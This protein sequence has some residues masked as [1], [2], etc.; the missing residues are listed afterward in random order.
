MKAVDTD[1][2]VRLLAKDDP[3]QTAVAQRLVKDEGPVWVS[4]LVLVET[5]WVLESVFDL[6]KERVVR[7][8]AALLDNVDLHLQDEL[9]VARAL[10]RFKAGGR[11]DFTDCL[12]LES[13]RSAGHLPLGTFDR[14]LARLPGTELL[15]SSRR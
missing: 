1:V 15:R 2:L 14:A 7:V 10:D 9:A 12:I 3:G 4:H 11:V 6:P 5:L 8:L 13:A